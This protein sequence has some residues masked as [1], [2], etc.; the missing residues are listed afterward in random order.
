MALGIFLGRLLKRIKKWKTAR[1]NEQVWCNKTDEDEEMRDELLFRQPKSSNLGD[2]PICCLPLSLDPQ[3]SSLMA[4]CSK[5]ICDG[6]LR[7]NTIRQ[8]GFVIPQTPSC[9]FCREPVPKTEEE[10]NAMLMKR[11]EKNDPEAMRYMGG[12]RRDEGDYKS[13][14]EYYT[15]AAE[16][17]DAEAHFNLSI[18]HLLGKGVEKDEKKEA[19]HLEVAAI[20]GHVLARHILG[21]HEANNG[22]MERAVEHFIIAASMGDKESMKALWKLHAKGLIKKETLTATLRAHQ[23]AVDATKSAQREQAEESLKRNLKSQEKTKLKDAWIIE[24]ES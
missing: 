20:G 22:R 10:A 6:C 24:A 21:C 16:L 14:S 1:T 19:Y 13:A 7:A 12:K 4:C 2:C 5:R 9:T 17:G 8:L 23:A 15:K 3:K 18:M 11:I